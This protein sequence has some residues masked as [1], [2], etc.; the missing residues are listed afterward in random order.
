MISRVA[1]YL[2]HIPKLPLQNFVIIYCNLKGRPGRNGAPGVKGIK[3]EPAIVPAILL[4]GRVGPKGDLGREL[5]K[6]VTAKIIM[7]QE[8]VR[9]KR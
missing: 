4:K 1:C 3:G 2:K 7:K 6:D 9:S 5:Y 8:I